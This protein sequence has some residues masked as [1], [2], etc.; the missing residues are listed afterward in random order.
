M[1]MQYWH[2]LLR[3]KWLSELVQILFSQIFMFPKNLENILK[4]LRLITQNRHCVRWIKTHK[5]T[6]RTDMILVVISPYR[7]YVLLACKGLPIYRSSADVER[8]AY[9]LKSVLPKNACKNN[10]VSNICKNNMHT[11]TF[12]N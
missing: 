6:M 1:T 5:F 11:G 7:L 3:S 10:Y 4:P 8:Q 9:L 12:G 2:I